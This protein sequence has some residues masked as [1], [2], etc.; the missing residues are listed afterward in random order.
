[1]N[2]DTICNYCKLSIKK[3]D[4]V[5]GGDDVIYHKFCMEQLNLVEDMK[6]RNILGVQKENKL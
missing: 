6:I 4:I 3:E 2:D 5:V 1:M